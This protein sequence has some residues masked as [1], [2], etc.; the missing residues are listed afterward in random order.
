[1]NQ[2][3]NALRSK[4]F[5][6]GDSLGI[7]ARNHRGLFIAILAGAKLGARTLLLNT[8][9]AGPQLVDVCVREDVAVLVHDEEFAAIAEGYEPPLGRVVAWTDTDTSE[10]IDALC[11]RSSTA[12]PARP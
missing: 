10:S 12:P 2:C 6:A 8:D 3:A 11:A 5:K 7:L 9:F 4:G 1:T